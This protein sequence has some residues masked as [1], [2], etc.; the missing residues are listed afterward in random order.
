MSDSQEED[1]SEERARAVKSRTR[2]P[3]TYVTDKM[4]L[5]MLLLITEFGL[6][7]YMAAKVLGMPYTNAK[8][9]YRVFRLDKRVV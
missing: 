9:I 2:K 4:R 6:S 8:V 7:C 5:K 3:M 1:S